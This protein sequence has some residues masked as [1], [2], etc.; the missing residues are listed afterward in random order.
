MHI[1]L[2]APPGLVRDGIARVV[3]ELSPSID[4]LC[5]DDVASASGPIAVPQLVV[6]DGDLHDEPAWA[7]QALRAQMSSVP[8]VVL[9]NVASLSAVEPLLKVGIAGCVEKSA[10]AGVFLGALR[11]AIAGG[12][13]LPPSLMLL[14]CK[15]SRPLDTSAVAAVPAERN[16]SDLTS[17][18]V[19]VLALAARGVSNKAIARRLSISEGTVK[20]HLTAVY[21]VLKVK[22]RTEA[23]NIAMRRNEVVDAQVKQAEGGSTALGRLI[24]HMTLQKIKARGVLFKKG[25]AS[26]SL[27]YV[28]KGRVHLAE[29]DVNVG[30]GTL[31]GEVGLFTAERKRTLTA[32]ATTDLDVLWITAIDAMR[33]C[34]Q[35]PEIA[36]YLMQ[37]ITGRLLDFPR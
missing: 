37:L 13:F 20:I 28:L 21:K 26:D 23:T 19:E 3:S 10:P 8:V 11:L 18:Q 33:I 25:D 6:L 32:R 9:L 5:V 17:R 1:L 30:P 12:T 29:I 36:L 16:P 34:Y 2:A 35:D 24:P 4:V 31:L 27:Y 7:V 22:N 15:Q 14:D